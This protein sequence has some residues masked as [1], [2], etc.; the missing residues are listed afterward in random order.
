MENN[1]ENNIEI[2]T[3]DLVEMRHI[4]NALVLLNGN[5]ALAAKKLGI[6]IKTLY[7]KLHKY[8]LMPKKESENV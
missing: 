8:G 6:S 1:N 7:N 2:E 5:K 4:T 3:L